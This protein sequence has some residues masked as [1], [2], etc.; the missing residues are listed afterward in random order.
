M[1]KNKIKKTLVLGSGALKIGQA[2]E[3]D[4]SGSQ[5]LKSLKEERIETVLINPNIATVQTD[6]GL[7]DKIYFL[8]ITPYFVIRVIERERPDSIALSFGG[9]TALNCGLE[10]A[11]QKILSRFHIR[12]LG[13]QIQSIED[14]EDRELF[15][16]KLKSIGVAAPRGKT[17]HSL[18]QGMRLAQ[19]I[20]YPVFMRL[21][22][23]L[24]GEGSGVARN[25]EDLKYLLIQAF[26][27]TKAVL[28]EEYLEGWKEIEYEMMRDSQGN[29]IAICNMENIDAMGIHTG[30]SIVVAPSQTLDNKE[31]HFLREICQKVVQS[32]KIVG[33]C[34]VQ[35]ALSPKSFEYR[36]IEVNARLSR[37]SALASKA[38]GYPIA[39]IAAKLGLGY[40]LPELQNRVTKKTSAFFEPALDYVVTKIPRWDL[41]KFK[42][43]KQ[44]IGPE[45]KS[46]GEVMAIG[47][48]FEESLQKAIRML[49]KGLHG[50]VLDNNFSGDIKQ[51]LETP[52]EKRILAAAR[53]IEQ[54][55]SIDQ[56]SALLKIDKWFLQKISNV[57]NIAKDIKQEKLSRELLLQAKQ[58]GFSDWQVGNIIGKEELAVRSLR[59]K[60]NIVP[61][62]KQID[63]MAAEWPATTNYLYTTYNATKHDIEKASKKSVLILGS[64]GYRIG[65]SVEFDWC[66]MNAV[67]ASQELGYETILINYNPETVS[68][69]FDECDRL[70]FDELS[71]ERVMDIYEFEQPEGM[72]V[73]MGG[74]I[75]NTIAFKCHNQHLKILGT[76]PESIDRAE[77]RAKFSKLLDE[78]GIAQPRWRELQTI[79]EAKWF[80][81]EVAYPVLIRPSYVLSGEAMVVV[82]EETELQKYL[83]RAARVSPEYPV[84]I[85]KFFTNAKEIELD[86]VAQQGEIISAIVSEHIE[87]AGT[88][89]GD[90]F[91]VTPSQ[92]VYGQTLREIEAIAK[93]IAKALEIT[94]PFN[95]QF[96]A[97]DQIVSVIECNVRS[98]RSFP[99]VSKVHH[100]NLAAQAT[101]AILGE[102][103]SPAEK[104]EQRLYVGVKAPQFSY[105]RLKGADPLP[106]VDMASTGEVGCLGVDLEEAFLKAAI[107]VGVDPPQKG[108][109]VS[110][111]GDK[112]KYELLDSV[113]TLHEM[114][115][116]LFGT[117]HTA[118]FF[119]KRKIP[120]QMLHKIQESKE[121]NVRTYM[122]K[123]KIDFLV[124]IPRENQ[125]PKSKS[126]YMMRREAVDSNVPLLT[127]TKVVK[128]MV[129]ALKKY[130]TQDQL[131]VREWREYR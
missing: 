45:M 29:C 60:W 70:Y 78:L 91:I 47:R 112:Q 131:G 14:T 123:K 36:V 67:K 7:A 106:S 111:G 20:G 101:K 21:G 13:T 48:T 49:E 72:I 85:S 108:I 93:K 73:S 2:G 94:G 74:Q 82:F 62:I 96:L 30:E 97:K 35:L 69:D 6:E 3:F 27:H 46:V 130:P 56:L 116:A 81:G 52:H 22:F 50:L 120:M 5:A 114:G 117:E 32:L 118:K 80:A 43:V 66:C 129:R 38:T 39:F 34:N 76:N 11:K 54:G 51:Y 68:T 10:L 77:N 79:K 24:G 110:I 107:S 100:I 65:S 17:V 121:P 42:N 61:F 26:Q 37:S 9:Q 102:K 84:V 31:Y 44:E 25:A 1:Q 4:Y 71:L 59:K 87:L 55:W 75:A 41:Q 127:N 104:T 119:A 126:A 113:K 103:L 63:T 109:L 58:A 125:N 57:V 92:R 86:A 28:I 88:H 8:P 83:E 95:I 33:E 18:A 53:A 12:V 40:A 19:R 99:F 15:R 89:S 105:S 23:A 64:G 98:S 128:V 115:Y 90:S 122:K 124:S 16:R